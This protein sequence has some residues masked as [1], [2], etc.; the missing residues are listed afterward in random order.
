[1]R[2]HESLLLVMS[3]L[4]DPACR[5]NQYDLCLQGICSARAHISLTNLANAHSIRFRQQAALD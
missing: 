2:C 4:V 3:S 1:M 5:R